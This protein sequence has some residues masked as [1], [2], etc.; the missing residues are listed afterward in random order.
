MAAKERVFAID[1]LRAIAIIGVMVVHSLAV[2]LGPAAINETWN[3]LEFV[4]ITFVLCSGYVNWL[5]F[6]AG[7]K[8]GHLLS[9][10]GKRFVRLYI[11]FIVYVA[12]YALLVYLFPAFIR[13]RVIALTPKFFVSSLFLTGGADV[14]WLTLLFLQLALITPFCIWI[15]RGKKRYMLSLCILGCITLAMVFFPVPTAYSR[16]VSWVPWSFIFLLGMGMA[17]YNFLAVTGIFAVIWAVLQFALLER[18]APLAF[19]LHKYPPDLFYLSYGVAASGIVFW[20]SKVGE[21]VFKKIYGIIMFFS[22]HSY[23]MFFTHVIVLDAVVTS[24]HHA[25]VIPTVFLSIAITA[26]VTFVWSLV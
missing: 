24:I 10:Y 22:T 12:G 23:G 9:W 16:A 7:N 11:P 17:R 6:S 14:G 26:L 4:V 3:Y 1:I 21:T 18:G 2:F 25:G 20:I 8:E 15:A 19:T 5:S 13:G